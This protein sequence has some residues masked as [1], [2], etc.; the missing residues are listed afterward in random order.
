M[1]PLPVLRADAAELS[2]HEGYLAAL[3]KSVGGECLW[4]KMEPAAG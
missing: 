2:E 1:R 3:D 4:R